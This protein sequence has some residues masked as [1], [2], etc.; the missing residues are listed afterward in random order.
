M[1]MSANLHVGNNKLKVISV[2]NVRPD[3]A[4]VFGHVR[5]QAEPDEVVLYVRKPEDLYAIAFECETL[6]RQWM[7]HNAG[8]ITEES[9]A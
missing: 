8:Q 1:G 2:R 5:I 7:E 9:N 3:G 4:V 6:A